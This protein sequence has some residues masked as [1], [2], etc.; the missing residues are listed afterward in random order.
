M[1]NI[2]LFLQEETDDPKLIPDVSKPMR[3]MNTILCHTS[4]TKE[5]YSRRVM[6]HDVKCTIA[7]V[8]D[9]LLLVTV[10]YSSICSSVYASMMSME[11]M[12]L[13]LVN[14][15]YYLRLCSLP[16][17]KTCI[18]NVIALDGCSIKVAGKEWRVS[19]FV[20][21][22]HMKSPFTYHGQFPAS[23]FLI[24]FA[25]FLSTEKRHDHPTAL[26]PPRHLPSPPSSREKTDTRPLRLHKERNHHWLHHWP[27]RPF[28]GHPFCGTTN[29]YPTL[30]ASTHHNQ[31]IRNH[32]RDGH[33]DGLPAVLHAD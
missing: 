3:V 22:K 17:L 18:F 10:E 2:S 33:A 7:Q 1:R 11:S 27:R 29:R 14:R 6:V 8:M 4:E 20:K 24:C 26:R 9:F 16:R 25:L 19:L 12:V 28:C 21:E 32:H 5:I 13:G 30:E 23:K 31:E 15:C